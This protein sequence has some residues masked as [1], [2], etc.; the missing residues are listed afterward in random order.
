MKDTIKTFIDDLGCKYCNRDRCVVCKLEFKKE[1][2]EDNKMIKPAPMEYDEFEKYITDLKK[3]LTYF[4][5]CAKIGLDLYNTSSPF[6]VVSLINKIFGRSDYFL[7]DWVAECDF[8]T[9][10][11]YILVE[12][13]FDIELINPTSIRDIYNFMLEEYMDNY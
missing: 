5:E 11:L 2:E 3:D 4:D 6:N 13:G 12:Y 8:G 1:N 9:T 7:M 10:R